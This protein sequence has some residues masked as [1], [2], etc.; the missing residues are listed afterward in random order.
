MMRIGVRPVGGTV[1]AVAVAIAAHPHLHSGSEC[2]AGESR[3]DKKKRPLLAPVLRD[4]FAPPAGDVGSFVVGALKVE[5]HLPPLNWIQQHILGMIPPP[6]DAVP[7]VVRALRERD[8]RITCVNRVRRP[9]LSPLACDV[10]RRGHGA[11]HNGRMDVRT[12]A[13]ARVACFACCARELAPDDDVH[14]GARYA[15][16]SAR[17]MVDAS[18]SARAGTR[19]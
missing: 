15:G 6:G 16:G 8:G 14:R 7:T 12:S 2:E 13:A 3:H 10:L 18:S 1:A 17:S 19:T 4:S 9:P 11:R 5:H